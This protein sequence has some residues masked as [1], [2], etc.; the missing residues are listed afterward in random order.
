MLAPNNNVV[1]H[2]KISTKTMIEYKKLQAQFR[3]L[4]CP[5]TYHSTNVLTILDVL[6]TGFYL[7]RDTS[8]H[9]TIASDNEIR[10]VEDD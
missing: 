9:L 10:K 1:F 5:C 6:P 4:I 8:N 2:T 7:L 3:D